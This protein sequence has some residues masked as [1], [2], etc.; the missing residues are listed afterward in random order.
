MNRIDLVAP[1]GRPPVRIAVAWDARALGFFGASG[2]GKS[3][4]LEAVAGLRPE[5]QGTI[6][7]GGRSLGGLAP[8]RRGV[9]LCTQ[10]DLLFPHMSLDRQLAC[11]A[12]TE[13]ARSRAARIV[14]LL[15]IGHL[16]SRV[17]ARMSGGERRRAALARAYATGAGILVLDEPF[18]G[19]DLLLQ[20]RI[21]P[22]LAGIFRQDGIQI[23]LSSHDPAVILELCGHVA[24]V[25]DGRVVD[26][27]APKDALRRA[28]ALEVGAAT[29]M[30]NLL[31]VEDAERTGATWRIRTRGGL[32][33]VVAGQ[34][35]AD[36]PHRLAVSADDVLVAVTPPGLVSAQNILPGVIRRLI[37]DK[38]HV[39]VATGCEG[40]EIVAKLTPRAIATLG[41][42][43]GLRVH[44]IIKAHGFLPVH[45]GGSTPD[46]Q[47]A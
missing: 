24:I 43:P 26:D 27:G 25:E 45:S 28:R 47:R 42:A 4:A 7:I 21:L 17:P 35:E 18:T 34:G 13:M 15:E 36:P 8:D 20:R 46:A 40:E 1:Y 19:L 38:D 44:L 37:E 11:V 23:L 12:R 41:I 39:Y 16:R 30:E 2:A 6:E 29:G 5:V 3:T 14:E 9:G 33:L 22:G 31:E 32:G 10:E